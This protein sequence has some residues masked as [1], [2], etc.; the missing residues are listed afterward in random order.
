MGVRANAI[1]ALD[2][3][4]KFLKEKILVALAA[5]VRVDVE[6]SAASGRDD[7]EFADLVLFAKILDQIHAAGADE[8]LFVFA[9]AVQKIKDRVTPAFFRTLP[10][11]QQHP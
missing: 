8:N 11:R 5:V 9:E 2:V 10:A 7:K 1:A 3:R 4:Q 6:A